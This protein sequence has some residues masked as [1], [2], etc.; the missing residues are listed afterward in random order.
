MDYSQYFNVEHVTSSI[1]MGTVF[2]VAICIA[3]VRFYHSIDDEG[4]KKALKK[5]KNIVPSIIVI[6]AIGFF[7]GFATPIFFDQLQNLM[8]E[9]KS[10]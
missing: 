1:I 7:M 9:I 8:K 2:C 10:M 6:F 3:T 5:P 4:F